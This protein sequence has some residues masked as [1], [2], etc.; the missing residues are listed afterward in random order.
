VLSKALP[1]FITERLHELKAK[2]LTLD[3][4]GCF[5]DEFAQLQKI[6][7]Q[8]Q[9]KVILLDGYQFSS[10]YRQKLSTIASEVIIFDDTNEFDFL[11]CDVVINALPFASRIGYDKSAP[12]AEHLLGLDYSII[13]K[14]FLNSSKQAFDARNKL[15]INFGGSDI[16]DLTLPLI[17]RLIDNQFVESL[18]DIIVIT[19]GAY[20]KSTQV[21][22]LSV[23]TGFTHIHNCQNMAD[24]LP[25]CKM[26]ICAPG[27]I[28]Y[29]LAYCAVPSIF[30]TVAENQL[31]S[32]LAHQNFGWCKVE[33]GL[34]DLGVD[35]ALQHAIALWQDDERLNVMSNL[36]KNLI[37]GQGVDRICG[38]IKGMLA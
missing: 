20:P 10:A 30:L 15:L 22:A 28:V 18:E 29:E 5:T 2:P 11:H 25:L 33:N 35:L 1:T 27:A 6:G 7:A 14:E 38:V 17:K 9:V 13:R 37:D 19:G 26:A 4:T 23:S 8:Y 3:T 16:A 34:N 36:A 32:A 24:I 31:L 21:N 12:H